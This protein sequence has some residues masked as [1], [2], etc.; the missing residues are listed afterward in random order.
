MAILFAAAAVVVVVVVVVVVATETDMMVGGGIIHVIMLGR[1]HST[2]AFSLW[3]YG[4]INRRKYQGK[5]W[6]MNREVSEGK[7]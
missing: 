2:I 7:Y 1:T 6:Q 5:N 4:L 3:T